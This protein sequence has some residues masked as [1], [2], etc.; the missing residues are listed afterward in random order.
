[1]QRGGECRLPGLL[2][3]YMFDKAGLRLLGCCVLTG[4]HTMRYVLC[5]L[6]CAVVIAHSQPVLSYRYREMV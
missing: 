2:D 6:S 1:M 3:L 4:Y 5:F